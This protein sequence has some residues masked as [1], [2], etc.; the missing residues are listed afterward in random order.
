MVQKTSKIRLISILSASILATSF[1]LAQTISQSGQQLDDAQRQREQSLRVEQERQRQLQLPSV[2]VP[3]AEAKELAIVVN[4]LPPDKVCFPIEAIQIKSASDMPVAVQRAALTG[5]DER[6]GFVQI[7]ANDLIN[8]MGVQCMGRE[9]I[10]WLMRRLSKAL[11]EKGYSTSRV[12]LPEQDLSKGILQI[13]LMPGLLNELRL[14]GNDANVNVW[15]AFPLGEGDVLNLRDL[16][17]GLE[18]IKRLNHVEAD[19][20][21]LPSKNPGMSD[22]VVSIRT[23]DKPWKLSFSL[24]DSGSNNTGKNQ[25]GV[26]FSYEN[27]LQL[28]DV[29]SLGAT[30]DIDGKG[31]Q[32]GTRSRNAYYAFPMGNWTHSL[33][34]SESN[35]YQ[36]IAGLY[37]T[38]VSHGNSQNWDWRT[39][40]SLLRGQST[41]TSLF[42]KLGKRYSRAYIDDAELTI[43]RRNLSQA[44]LGI[45]HR[46]KSPSGGQLDLSLTQRWGGLAWLDGQIDA[47][48]VAADAAHFGYSL[49]TLD[50]NWNQPLSKN[51]E[52]KY[53]TSFRGQTTEQATYGSEWINLGGRWSVRG[54]DGSLSLASNQGFYWRNDIELALGTSKLGLYLGVDYG[55]LYGQN[56]ANLLGA[57]LSGLVLGVRGSPWKGVYGD[58]FV[59]DQIHAPA[60]YPHGSAVMGF[61]L[62]YQ[63]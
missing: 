7:L 33:S 32:R 24:D 12:G 60:G 29:F 21:I 15:T 20:Q 4:S 54:F 61:S 53:I 9:R 43:Q 22:V 40:Y 19:M 35:Y 48:D 39:D 51:A 10:N 27:P 56:L 18:Q 58:F 25:M 34:Y 62:N 11:L 47:Q 59:S 57:E 13:V 55:R 14:V 49:Q 16:E 30:G 1:T 44:E 6:F 3:L 8:V 5:R 36:K 17:Q 52:F 31:D 26:S 41:K 23:V 37:Q 45:S 46:Y 63:Y 38:F 28:N 42:M 2:Q 50:L